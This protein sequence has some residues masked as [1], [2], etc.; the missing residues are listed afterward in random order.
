M[1]EDSTSC[2]LIRSYSNCSIR[3]LFR[4]QL[5]RQSPKLDQRRKNHRPSWRSMTPSLPSVDC[6]VP[7]HRCKSI[8][9]RTNQIKMRES[10]PITRAHARAVTDDRNWHALLSL[11]MAK[12]RVLSSNLKY[13][14]TFSLDFR[15]HIGTVEKIALRR[16]SLLVL[17]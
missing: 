15:V 14:G 6:S 5:H 9:S 1:Q 8:S 12:F 13:L 17:F 4:E 10:A 3:P 16:L 2:E 11:T 7:N